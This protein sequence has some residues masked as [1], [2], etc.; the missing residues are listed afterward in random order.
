[1]KKQA[2]G[3]GLGALISE[4]TYESKN[5]P[6]KA[7]N[8]NDI[9]IENIETNPNQPRTKFDAESLEELAASIREL[10][11]IQPITVRKL[12]SGKFQ[13][14]SGERRYRASQLAGLKKIPAFI[15]EVEDNSVLEMALVENI[16]REDLNAIEIAI[17][18]QRLIEECK[19]T[20]ESM[21]ERVGKK[22]TTITNYLRLLKLPAEIQIAVRDQQISM[23]HARSLVSIEKKDDQIS[24]LFRIINEN[25]SV[26][27]VE[28]L[29][30]KLTEPQPETVEETEKP[31][32]E[33]VEMPE[34]YVGFGNK[35]A[36]SLNSKV[37]IK[38]ST[39]GKGNISITFKNDNEL[40]H[41]IG[42]LGMI[43]E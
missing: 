40:D 4:Q 15:R 21:S 39:D 1:M 5:V 29:T 32:K 16:Q 43:T 20:Q 6:E 31:K 28:D 18:Y 37:H 26:R 30:R 41:I 33:E 2:L 19:L 10:G 17:T 9:E 42:I 13:I 38:R 22:R 23:G 24:L 14:I 34:K 36:E 25:L 3:R 12:D 11:I 7:V 35:L 8:L 27:Q